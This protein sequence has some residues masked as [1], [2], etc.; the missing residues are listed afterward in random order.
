MKYI[1]IILLL[2][3]FSCNTEKEVSPYKYKGAII[4]EKIY[5]NS[6]CWFKINHNDTIKYILIPKYYYDKYCE[7]DTI[8]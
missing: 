4:I 2:I 5:N 6:Y 1:S 3:L 8:K 7:S